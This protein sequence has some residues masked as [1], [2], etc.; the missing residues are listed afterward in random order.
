MREAILQLS[1]VRP[2]KGFSHCSQMAEFLGQITQ[3]RPPKKK[4]SW[5][6]KNAEIAK[7][8]QKRGRKNCYNNEEDKHMIICVLLVFFVR[9]DPKNIK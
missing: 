7:K 1:E 5:A 4:L 3:N 6:V 9:Y 8:W 2:I